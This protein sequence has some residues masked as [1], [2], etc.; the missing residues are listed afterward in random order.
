[1]PSDLNEA[2]RRILQRDLEQYLEVERITAPMKERLLDAALSGSI[3]PGRW[4]VDVSALSNQP[5]VIE[6][7][8]DPAVAAN[9]MLESFR[10]VRKA[11]TIGTFEKDGD[12]SPELRKKLDR[13]HHETIQYHCRRIR[14]AAYATWLARYRV[15]FVQA[16]WD[17]AVSLIIDRLRLVEMNATVTLLR[18]SINR[19]ADKIARFCLMRLQSESISL[20]RT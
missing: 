17:D 14:L 15:A 18:F 20:L 12:L 5:V 16:Q 4:T 3:E 6:N 2:L 7:F 8:S 11:V 19:R 13:I 10:A 9:A 1:M